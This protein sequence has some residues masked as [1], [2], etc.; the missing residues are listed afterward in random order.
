[1]KTKVYIE[2]KLLVV[3]RR[4]RA[5][6]VATLTKWEFDLD[7]PKST[8]TEL[9]FKSSNL[10]IGCVGDNPGLTSECLWD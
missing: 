9:Y 5:E 6:T 10:A 1:M 4:S 2:G 7:E 3:S 8:N